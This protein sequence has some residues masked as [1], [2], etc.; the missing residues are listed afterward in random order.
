M[1]IFHAMNKRVVSFLFRKR[2]LKHFFIRGSAREIGVGATD[3][4]E[5][6]EVPLGAGEG[7]GTSPR[8]VSPVDLAIRGGG[9]WLRRV[10]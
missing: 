2:G 1:L 8:V 10:E 4:K 9:H 7:K 6:D 3:R 5:R